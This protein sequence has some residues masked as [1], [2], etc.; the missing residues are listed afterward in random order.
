[1][2]YLENLQSGYKYMLDAA[3]TGRKNMDGMLAPVNGAISS[4]TGAAAE[5]EGIPFVGPVIGAKLQRITGA[6]G[7]AQSMVGQVAA[8]YGRATQAAAALQD[9]VAVMGAQYERA[10]AVVGKLAS[11]VTTKAA[12]VVPTAALAPEATPAPEAVKA[13]PHLMIL[14]PLDGKQ[15][16][17]YFN[18]DTAAFDELS[19][20]TAFRW[21]NQE[22]LG[23]RPAQQAI[24]MGDEKLTIKGAIFPTFKGGFKQ[25]DTLRSIGQQLKPLGLVT[26]YGASLGNWCLVNLNEDQSHL[27]QGGI[28]RKQSFTLEFA[29]YGDDMQNV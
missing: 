18:L 13:Y 29:R 20:S 28:P 2:E 7:R 12:A 17:Y 8:T 5:L 24:G 19:R 11:S 21:A 27:L 4:M 15:P 26:G 6:I 16:P 25:L 10:K 1:M 3:Q 22:R 23:R 14:Q 9:R